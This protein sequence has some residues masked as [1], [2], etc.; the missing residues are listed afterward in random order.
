MYL[1]SILMHNEF[2]TLRGERECTPTAAGVALIVAL[3]L[4]AMLH[5]YAVAD[6]LNGLPVHDVVERLILSVED[7]NA[8][9]ASFDL[10]A[11]FTYIRETVA[12]WKDKQW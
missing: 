2:D 5:P 12:I 4:T 3:A 6:W 11:P 10:H 7:I 8:W 1:F 9:L